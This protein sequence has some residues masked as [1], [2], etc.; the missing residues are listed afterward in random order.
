M[1]KPVVFDIETKH[2]FREFSDPAKLKVSMVCAYDYATDKEYSF[3][4]DELSGLFRLFE[5]A[6]YVVGFNSNSFDLPV[7]QA[8]YPGDIM[9][10]SR[11]DMLE[12]VKK[13][14]GRRLSLNDLASATLGAKKSGNGLMAIDYYRKGKWDELQKYCM[15]DTILTKQLLDY[16]VEHGQIFYLSER[17]KSPIRMRWKRY[18]M[19]NESAPDTHLA[20]P[21]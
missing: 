17:G 10:F 18:M 19:E 7:L 4:E 14:L 8:Y 12:D 1:R 9:Q 5:E 2:T 20:L 16:G 6:S 13:N 21:F 15:D 11:F 3:R